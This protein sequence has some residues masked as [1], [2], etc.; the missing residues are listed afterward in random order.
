MSPVEEVKNHA[1]NEYRNTMKKLE[2][3]CLLR[4]GIAYQDPR[5]MTRVLF[6]PPFRQ[7]LLTEQS[8]VA[9]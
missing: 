3:G 8:V 7:V 5:T 6:T 4:D 1:S 2:L 9:A